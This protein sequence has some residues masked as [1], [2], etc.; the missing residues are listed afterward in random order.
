[1][2]RNNR[3]DL[4]DVVYCNTWEVGHNPTAFNKLLSKNFCHVVMRWQQVHFPAESYICPNLSGNYIM[5]VIHQLQ[6]SS[7]MEREVFESSSW[8]LC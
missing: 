2:N 5:S 3:S 1:M 8:H 7:R 6:G 4:V